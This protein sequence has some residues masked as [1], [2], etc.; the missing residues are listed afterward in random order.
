MLTRMVLISWPRDPPASASQSAGITGLS[1]HAQPYVL[2]FPFFFSIF[3]NAIEN[4]LHLAL[5]FERNIF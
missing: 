4:Y 5:T 3:D 2:Y 1:D